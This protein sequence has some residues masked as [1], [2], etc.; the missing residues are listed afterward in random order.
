MPFWKNVLSKLAMVC[1]GL[2]A[3]LL[4]CEVVLHLVPEKQIARIF[5]KNYSVYEIYQLNEEIGWVH[6]PNNVFRWNPRDEFDTEVTIN[7]HGLRDRERTYQKPAGVFR[8]L[9]LGDS[10]AESIQVPMEQNYPSNLEACLSERLNRP[11]EVLN[12][13]VAGYGPGDE[14]LFYTNEGRK[15]QP[16][17][18]LASVCVGNDITDLEREEDDSSLVESIGGYRF[19]LEGGQLQKEWVSWSNPGDQVPPVERFLRLNSRIYQ[20]LSH[21]SSKISEYLEDTV[22]QLQRDLRPTTE[23]EE[24]EQK[25]P[26]PH[27]RVYIYVKGFP[28]APIIPDEAEQMWAIF[29]AIY[30]EMKAQTTA[31]DTH[32][33]TVLIPGAHE[34][35][36]KEYEER[37]QEYSKWWDVTVLLKQKASWDTVTPFEAMAEFMAAEGIPTLNLQPTFHE[38]NVA[39]GRSLFFAQDGH[40]NPEGH[41]LAAKSLC[42]WLI[43]EKLVY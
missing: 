35:Q 4:I 14:L 30:R 34:A 9:V 29:K 8:V 43:E 19:R 20:V 6:V 17:L 42:D 28:D 1:L 22:D 12:G 5:Y 24:K 15:Y 32:L 26:P 37:L 33:A 40:L 21:P 7:S 25:K 13:G 27:W 11:V 36:D 18:V 10:L 3:G 31:D 38:H 2:L 23:T 16:D 41:D 39:T